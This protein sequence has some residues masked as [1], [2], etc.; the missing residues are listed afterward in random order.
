MP[1]LPLNL[2]RLFH[3]AA[4]CTGVML[5]A[6]CASAQ[7]LPTSAQDLSSHEGL[8]P[9]AYL[10]VATSA[11][12]P[13]LREQLNLPRGIGL[14]VDS[15]EPASPAQTAGLQ[16]NDVLHRLEDQLL[17]NVHQF[18]VLLRTYKPGDNVALS[19]IRNGQPLRIEATLGGRVLPPIF[20][21]LRLGSTEGSGPVVPLPRPGLGRTTGII[22]HTDNEHVVTLTACDEHVDVIIR[23]RSGALIYEGPLNTPEDRARVPEAL[24][25][26]LDRIEATGRQLHDLHNA[27][28]LSPPPVE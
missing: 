7:A 15:V 20:E 22:T 5:L 6:T 24:R 13:T 14:L 19:V 9:V 18:A 8:V 4:A 10:G 1:R 23:D 21:P 17:I 11:V 28:R 26:K 25:L 27:S 2:A 12:P 3:T 16:P